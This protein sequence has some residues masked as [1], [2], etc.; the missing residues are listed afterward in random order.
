M[1]VIASESSRMDGQGA[2][3]SGSYGIMV[4]KTVQVEARDGDPAE[5]A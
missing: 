5:F 3:D 1:T 2:R 4:T